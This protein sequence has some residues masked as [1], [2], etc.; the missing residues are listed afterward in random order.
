MPS[1]PPSLFAVFSLGANHQ[2]TVSE[3]SEAAS[4]HGGTRRVPGKTGLKTGLEPRAA[5]EPWANEKGLLEHAH[6]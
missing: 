2:D 3:F 6:Q 1:S 4:V 5:C